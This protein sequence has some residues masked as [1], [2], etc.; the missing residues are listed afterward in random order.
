MK[1]IVLTTLAL[2]VL[3]LCS[4]LFVSAQQEGLKFVEFEEKIY[5]GA[6][7]DD[8]FDVSSVLVVMD[9]NH[10]CPI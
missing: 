1:K 5:S 8:D 2:F 10:C 4:F 6:S 3:L 7:I 9:K